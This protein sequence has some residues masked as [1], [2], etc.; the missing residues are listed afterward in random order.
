[1]R[2]LFI[3]LMGLISCKSP[4]SPKPVLPQIQYQTQE[5]NFPYQ[6]DFQH[7]FPKAQWDKALENATQELVSLVLQ[8][9]NH[10]SAESMQLAADRAG[11]PGQAIFQ[12]WMN[13]GEFPKELLKNIP[14]S[15]EK[16]DVAISSRNYGDGRVL[17][18]MGF[19]NHSLNISPMPRD[20][21][22]DGKLPIWIDG[23]EHDQ[24][25]YLYIS[26][27][28]EPIEKIELV[29]N[30]HRWLGDFH[31]PGKYRMEV[32]IEED[33]KASVALLFSVFV[34]EKPPSPTMAQ[35][36][37]QVSNPMEAEVWLFEEVNRLRQE[38]GLK[39]LKPF[40]LFEDIVREHSAY[41]A[42]TGI[43]DHQI[44]NVTNGVA[45]NAGK[46]AHPKAKHYQ[47]VAAAMTYQEALSL[48]VD[49]PGHFQVLLCEQCTHMVIG[50]TLEPKLQGHPRLFVTWE[51]LQF[52]D[53]VPKK[54]D[55]LNRDF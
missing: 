44:P 38:R 24:K 51:V 34:D 28:F 18:V 30:A 22:L 2:L 15:F 5:V 6:S 48:A 4:E 9:Q 27:P 43:V 3:V 41:M 47:N 37:L 39:P 13:G 40:V 42:S 31:A 10:L 17:W 49:S 12:K 35:S 29:P 7:Y 1:M 19:A 52:T 46:F 55:K 45:Y 23:V 8:P 36:T 26:A 50:A 20:L 16:V 11:F 21:E 25:A 32:V 14:R 53:G 33:E 54:I